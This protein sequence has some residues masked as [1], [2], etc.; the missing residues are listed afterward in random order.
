MKL[1]TKSDC[2]THSRTIVRGVFPSPASRGYWQTMTRATPSTVY[3]PS[4][5]C[6]PSRSFPFHPSV[7]HGDP[8]LG[9][10]SCCY[11]VSDRDVG[12]WAGQRAVPPAHAGNSMPRYTS[13]GRKAR[14]AFAPCLTTQNGSLYCTSLVQITPHTLLSST[15][16]P[17]SAT[18]I[19]KFPFPPTG[20]IT[21]FIF[22]HSRRQLRRL[23]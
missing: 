4:P 15:L 16:S 21:A 9:V 6:P 8:R 20:W 12:R 7:V 18:Q 13:P 10:L 17:Y 11:P 3:P 5:R 14:W 22:R 2:T 23:L 19:R 1:D